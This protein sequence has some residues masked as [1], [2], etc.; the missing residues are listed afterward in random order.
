MPLSS[1]VKRPV[2]NIPL[3]CCRGLWVVVGVGGRGKAAE[4]GAPV[5][6]ALYYSL[7]SLS[8]PF[9]K[10]TLISY[11]YSYTNLF[12]Y[13]QELSNKTYLAYLIPNL[14]FIIQSSCSH[15]SL[16]MQYM[17]CAP[18]LLLCLSICYLPPRLCTCPLL[19]LSFHY[20]CFLAR[21]FLVPFF[22]SK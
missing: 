20:L 22:K 9:F 5:T 7:G 17:I 14:C 2:G 13:F 21:I 6:S 19:A 8:F 18:T 10:R 4:Q 11:V 12:K 16:K 15:L 3:L 1:V